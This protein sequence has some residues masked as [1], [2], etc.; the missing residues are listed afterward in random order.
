MK[1]LQELWAWLL[2]I[3]PTHNGETPADEEGPATPKEFNEDVGWKLDLRRN[4]EGGFRWEGE[5]Y[6]DGKIIDSYIW[7]DTKMGAKFSARKKKRSY[8]KKQLSYEHPERIRKI[9]KI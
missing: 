7:A 5:L 1:Y 8:L 2:N 4:Y 3:I 9:Y 6:R